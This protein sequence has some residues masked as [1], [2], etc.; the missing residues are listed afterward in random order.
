MIANLCLFFLPSLVVALLTIFSKF[1]KQNF[2]N[3]SLI[4]AATLRQRMA[5]DLS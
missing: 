4:P 2:Q 1:Q 5:A 3:I